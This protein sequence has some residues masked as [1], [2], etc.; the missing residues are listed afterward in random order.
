M[1][2]KLRSKLLRKSA[3]FLMG[4]EPRE[5]RCLEILRD[6]VVGE[7]ATLTCTISNTVC[8]DILKNHM[9]IY[10]LAVK[11]NTPPTTSM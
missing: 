7:W 10:P 2:Y 1:Q 6:L 11:Q 5:I 4:Q 3:K 9:R 8:I